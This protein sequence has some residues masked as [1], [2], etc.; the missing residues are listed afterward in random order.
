[1]FC[2]DAAFESFSGIPNIQNGC[3]PTVLRAEKERSLHIWDGDFDNVLSTASVSPKS[4]VET[5]NKTSAESIF[6]VK[7]RG[8]KEKVLHPAEENRNSAPS[9]QSAFRNS[10]ETAEKGTAH[11]KNGTTDVGYSSPTFSSWQAA[12]LRDHQNIVSQQYL[13]HLQANPQNLLGAP[14]YNPLLVSGVPSRQLKQFGAIKERQGPDEDGKGC[15]GRPHTKTLGSGRHI[16][17]EDSKQGNPTVPKFGDWE[18]GD[19][20]TTIFNN[21]R[22]ERS[23]KNTPRP[24]VGVAALQMEEDLYKGSQQIKH[25]RS[26]LSIICCFKSHM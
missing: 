6:P 16:D 22:K 20:F 26:W 14:T 4:S 1:M 3:F 2:D 18:H 21:M 9:H 10:E 25:R 7:G 17:Q 19:G 13:N 24:T 11:N 15:Q 8:K 5:G 23:S 12:V